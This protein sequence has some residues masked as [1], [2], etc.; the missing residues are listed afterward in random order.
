MNEIDRI[1]AADETVTILTKGG[2]LYN[3][4][5]NDRGQLGTGAGTGVEYI[6]GERYPVMVENNANRIIKEFSIGDGSLMFRDS[7]DNIFRSGLKVSY[8]P[9]LLDIDT[10]IHV[11]SF[12][13]GNS[14]YSIVTGR[15]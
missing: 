2:R 9:T 10:K 8:T 12:L 5:K 13:A 14:S 11:K 15:K 6:E 1:D 3:W 4:G 7:M